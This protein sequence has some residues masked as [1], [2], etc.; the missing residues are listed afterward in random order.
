MTE[1][2]LKTYIQAH[3]PIENEACEWKEFKSLKHSFS[4]KAGYDIISYI[5]AIGNMEGGHLVIGIEDGTHEIVGIQDFNNHTAQNIKLRLLGKCSNLDSENF[6]VQEFITS[7]TGKTVWVIHIPKHLPRQPV[8]AHAMLWQR[9]EDSLVEMRPERKDAILRE[10]IARS[11]D[12][13]AQIIPEATIDDLDPVAIS[14]ARDEYKEKHPKRTTECDN[15]DNSTFL[16]KA[17]VTI[18]GKITNTA[19]LLLGKEESAHFLM[20]AFAK[21]SWILKDYDNIERDYEHFSLPVI[22]ASNQVFSRIR[23]LTYRYMQDSSLFP[24]EIKMYDN[25]VIREALHNCIAHQ[26]YSLQGRITVVEK[27]NELVFSNVG[28]FI[29]KNV[30][31]VIEQDAP[32]EYYRNAFLAEAMVNLNMIDTIGSGIKRM[33]IEQRKRFFP[34]PD[35]D[36]SDPSKVV[37]KIAGRIWDEN[38]T[39][40]LMNKTDLDLKTVILLD[41]VQKSLTIADEEAK[42]LKRI[43]LIEGRKPNLY[44]S[45]SIAQTSGDK[46]TYIKLRGFKDEHYK[47][48]ILEYLDKYK[49]A[50]KT[51]IDNLI[52]DILPD[53]LDEQKKANKVRN[54]IY[55][56]SKKDQTI[57]NK[58]T[59]RYPKWKKV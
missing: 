13:S 48:L 45:A 14:K 39:R 9:I 4:G 44:V 19:L 41:R 17:K 37:V 56:M 8:Y 36:I 28:S 24:T 22:L 18:Q 12:W 51:D 42:Q 31:T 23:N 34:L 20:P 2:E 40:L 6:S 38:Y 43:G 53:I 55:A 15:W 10:P 59:T 11:E 26:D 54:I 47:K 27:P 5:S 33:F 46:S 49:Q 50:S 58:G 21:I 3:F 30:E 25:F 7:D 32:Q 1:T 57:V 29:P 16:N 35:F 52:L